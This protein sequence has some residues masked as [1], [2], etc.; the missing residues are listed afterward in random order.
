MCPHGAITWVSYWGEWKGDV[1]RRPQLT[2]HVPTCPGGLGV[3]SWLRRQESPA[4]LE[5]WFRQC[6]IFWLL[7]R[8]AGITS[9]R[10]GPEGIQ[11]GNL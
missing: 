10:P 6:F 9:E 8:A 1:D 3:L 4:F 7:I 5:S 2:R 11:M